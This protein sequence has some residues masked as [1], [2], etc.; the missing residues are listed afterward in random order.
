MTI[1]RIVA[2]IN[3]DRCGKLYHT[4]LDEGV[5]APSPDT[6]PICSDDNCHRREPCGLYCKDRG[7][8]DKAAAPEPIGDNPELDGTDY[9]HPAW[10]RGNDR[11]VEATAECVLRYL[12]EPSIAG[13]V[14]CKKLQKGRERIHKLRQGAAVKM[15]TTGVRTLYAICKLPDGRLQESI[16]EFGQMVIAST[17]KSAIERLASRV[18]L[19]VVQFHEGAALFSDKAETKGAQDGGE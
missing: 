16:T 6:R 10:W 7:N 17:D 8:F 9:A 4:L 2:H 5:E 14:N 18:E 15:P 12:D 3:C 11:G 19:E 13:V 1:L